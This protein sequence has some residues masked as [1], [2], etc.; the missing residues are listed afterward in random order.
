MQPHLQAGWVVA[1]VAGVFSF[2]SPCVLLLIPGYLSMISGLTVKHLRERPGSQLLPILL[3]CVLFSA[4][5]TP[6]YIL[7]GLSAGTIGSWLASYRTAINVVFGMVLIAFGLFVVG[8]L[9]IPFLYGERRL[10]IGGTSLG[11][12]GAPLVG[13]VFAFG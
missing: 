11:I 2:L 4:G 10:R 3:S 13:L 9:R 12:W 5:F 1:A 8:L 7:V 6:V